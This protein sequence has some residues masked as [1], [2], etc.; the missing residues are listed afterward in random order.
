M[1]DDS[2]L[3]QLVADSRLTGYLAVASLC[4]LIYEHIVCIPE[5]VELMWKSRW[6]IAKIIYLWNR[7]FIL[8]AVS[9]NTSV[10]VRDIRGAQIRNAGR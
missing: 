8:V 2:E 1:S 6:S 9:L 7:Y 3:L 10:V 5:E 4:V